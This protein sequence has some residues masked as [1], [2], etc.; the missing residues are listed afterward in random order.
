MFSEGVRSHRT[1]HNTTAA[2]NKGTVKVSIVP[3]AATLGNKAYSPNPINV[4]VGD[5]VAWTNNDKSDTPFHTVTSGTGPDDENKGE[6]CDSGLCG[7]TALMT[8]G[9]TFTHT[10]NAAGEFSYFCQL[11]QTMVGKVVITS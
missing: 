3:G 4:K 9:T 11:H 7:A 5:T 6:V 2:T 1:N 8:T 10:F